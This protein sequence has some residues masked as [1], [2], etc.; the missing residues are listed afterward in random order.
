MMAKKV[1][2]DWPIVI[3]ARLSKHNLNGK[4]FPFK[5]F[6]QRNAHVVATTTTKYNAKSSQ[7][8][9]RTTTAAP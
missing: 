8:Y 6:E 4:I 3:E 2:Y 1:L 5:K 7:Q 9:Y